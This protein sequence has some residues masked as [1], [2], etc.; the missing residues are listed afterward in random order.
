MQLLAGLRRRHPQ[1]I[2]MTITIWKQPGLR[3]LAQLYK[4]A[5]R[6]SIAW[7][8]APQFEEL[9]GQVAL[10]QQQ[11]AACA[12]EATARA[13]WFG[14]RCE[15][16]ERHIGSLQASLDG[17]ARCQD[18]HAAQLSYL[19]ANCIE[20]KDLHNR[21]TVE[22][23]EEVAR[24]R[25]EVADRTAAFTRELTRI[26]ARLGDLDDQC[27]ALRSADSCSN[28]AL[29]SQKPNALAKTPTLSSSQTD[30]YT[31]VARLAVCDELDSDSGV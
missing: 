14:Q 7:H 29:E 9:R 5:A 19:L 12:H 20:L 21:T 28:A 24:L 25:Q 13:E 15:R 22:T 26:H 16:L 10:L 17:L 23:A 8:V 6:K 31:I 1:R 4:R 3:W 18:A 11:L 30:S 2:T 27:V